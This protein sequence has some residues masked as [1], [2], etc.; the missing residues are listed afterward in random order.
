[1]LQSGAARSSNGASGGAL[2]STRFDSGPVGGKENCRSLSD[3]E[4][5]AARG[6]AKAEV[7]QWAAS[8]KYGLEGWWAR[9]WARV[10]EADGHWIWRG[11]SHGGGYGVVGFGPQGRLLRLLVHRVAFVYVHGDL[12]AGED[13]LHQCRFKGCVRCLKRGT[14]VD[15]N[16]DMVRDGTQVRTNQYMTGARSREIAA[17]FDANATAT[18]AAL[19]RE[20]GVTLPTV[21]RA[22]HCFA[23]RKPMRGRRAVQHG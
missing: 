22:V 21:Y 3:S 7:D 18:C 20:Y 19:A 9:F 15:N 4:P 16:A 1:M 8:S 11:A 10:E 13:A 5:T 14:Q 23:K 6:L 12:A 17:R 2:A